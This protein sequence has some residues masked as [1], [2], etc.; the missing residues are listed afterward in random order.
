[1]ALDLIEELRGSFADR[2]ALTLINR[3]QI[4]KTGFTLKENGSVHMDD[5]TKKEVLAAWHA[6][7]QEEIAQHI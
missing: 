6:R 3:K 4:N 7:K 1:L 5:K 2:L